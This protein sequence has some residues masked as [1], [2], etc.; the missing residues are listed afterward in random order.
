MLIPELFTSTIAIQP[1]TAGSAL[2][3]WTAGQVLEAT[4]VRQGLDGT[5]TLRVGGQ[6]L[7]ARTGL[8]L[9]ADQALTLQVAQSGTQTVLRILNVSNAGAT[10]HSTT[11]AQATGQTP[12]ATLIQAWR[13]VLPREGNLRPLLAQLAGTGPAGLPEPAAAAL[14]QFS[15]TLPLLDMLTSPA[16]LKRA[17]SDSGIFLEAHLAQALTDNTAPAVQNDIK[18]N[19]LQLVVQLRSLASSSSSATTGSAHGAESPLDPALPVLLRQAD[20]ALARI[21]QNQLATLTG[22]PQ[23]ATL[24]AVDLPV[25]QA[26]RADVLELNIEEKKSGVAAGDTVM[27]WSVWLHFDFEQLGKV[28]ARITLRGEEVAATL[29]AEHGP[30]A[31]LFQQHLTTLEGALRQ[32]GLVPTTVHCQ[33]GAPPR[34]DAPSA[35]SSL[36]DLR[37]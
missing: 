5:V 4:V 19:L 22:G 21:E 24:L 1:Q 15:A 13:Q 23:S 18:A 9:A 3:A 35:P 36:L 27:P 34:P 6:E 30:T 14:K 29:W 32:A 31:A 37:A 20:A 17:V 12:E 8:N 11:L 2:R 26:Q 33:T 25:H 7:Q 16:G 10:P 28:H